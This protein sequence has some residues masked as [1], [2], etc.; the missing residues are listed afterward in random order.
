MLITDINAAVPGGPAV[1]RADSLQYW[2]YLRNRTFF[3]NP[4]PVD[5]T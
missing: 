4:H 1:F 5:E 3:L 2:A